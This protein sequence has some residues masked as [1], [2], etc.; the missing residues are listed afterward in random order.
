MSRRYALLL[1]LLV[2]L[3]ASAAPA[4]ATSTSASAASCE[5]SVV[6][7][8]YLTNNETVTKAINQ[9]VSETR[10]NTKTTLSKD[11][12]FVRLKAENPNGYCVRFTTKIST[13]IVPASEIGDVDA[14]DTENVTAD[15]RAMH[16]FTIDETYTRVEFTV[17]ANTTVRFAPSR[18]KVRS[19]SWAGK[20]KTEGSGLLA[21]FKE[22]YHNLTHDDLEQ[23]HYYLSPSNDSSTLISVALSSSDGR[24]IE[25]WHALYRAEGDEEWRQV[26]KD[27]DNAVFYRQLNNDTVQF[28]FNDADAEVKFVANPTTTDDWEY[29]YA[30]VKEGINRLFE[31]F[32]S[33]FG[34]VGGVPT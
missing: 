23:R 30:A 17:P 1:V 5:T 9:T 27:S 21:S 16:D 2:S 26:N 7:D 13:D 31:S 32:T 28:I 4:G 33:P 29:E 25:E 18:F 22:R 34:L 10:D 20:A 24:N 8:S 3:V 14:T 6:H 15:W 11:N 12:G 19:L